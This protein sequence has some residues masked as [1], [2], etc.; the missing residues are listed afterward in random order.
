MVWPLP[1]PWS[2]SPS[3]HCKPHE[4]RIFCVWSALCWIW[5][6]RPRAQGVGVDPC[7]L[8]STK[9]NRNAERTAEH[10]AKAEQSCMRNVSTQARP[11]REKGLGLNNPDLK[12]SQHHPHRPTGP[13]KPKVVGGEGGAEGGGVGRRSFSQT[14]KRRENHNEECEM[15]I[16]FDPHPQPWT[17]LVRISVCNQSL[18][19]K[20]LLRI[21]W[22][23]Q[24]LLPLQFPGHSLPY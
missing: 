10:K 11:L 4:G 18:G 24:K 7:L 19:W 8:N 6:R 12:Q 5:S 20:F 13:S 9:S 21:T 3:E 2:P 23:G 22:S 16:E 17:S 15:R 1:R 14:S